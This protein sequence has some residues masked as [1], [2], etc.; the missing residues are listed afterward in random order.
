MKETAVTLKKESS[1]YPTDLLVDIYRLK[2]LQ[3]ETTDYI[4]RHNIQ[5]QASL[6]PPFPPLHPTPS[7]STTFWFQIV[8]LTFPSLEDFR[9]PVLVNIQ[10]SNHH[11]NSMFLI[12]LSLYIKN[13]ILKDTKCFN[14]ISDKIFQMKDFSK[15]VRPDFSN[16]LSMH[17]DVILQFP[18][19]LQ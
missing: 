7:L 3:L 8:F 15:K 9:T 16:L 11:H 5:P 2:S 10:H 1:Y 18:A 13:L 14:N 12:T 4:W 6:F 17:K 19:I